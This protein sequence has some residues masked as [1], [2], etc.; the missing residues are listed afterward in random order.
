MTTPD[1]V[2]QCIDSMVEAMQS[3]AGFKTTTEHVHEPDAIMNRL[4]GVPGNWC[5][6]VYEGSRASSE[7]GFSKRGIGTLLSISLY[8]V[9]DA[10]V[11]FAGLKSETDVLEVLRSMR[12]VIMGSTPPSGHPWQFVMET[13]VDSKKGKLLW[14]QRWVTPVIHPPGR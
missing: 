3:I 14:Q 6:V 1:K 11:G 7:E 5:G 4:S 8:P 12:Q 13:Y 2:K 10:N 9:I